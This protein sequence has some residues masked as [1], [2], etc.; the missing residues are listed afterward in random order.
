MGVELTHEKEPACR[1]AQRR[2]DV[3][4][5]PS[6]NGIDF[7]EYA[8]RPADPLPHVL[9]VHFLKDLPDAPHSDPDGAYDLIAHPVWI[10]LQG[11]TRIVNLRVLA[12]TLDAPVLT[13]ALDRAGDFSTYWLSLGW[14]RRPDGSL[15][16]ETP[17]LDA[18]FSRAPV[19]FK[20]DCPSAFDC[21]ED[22]FCPPEPLDEPL[23]D[24][25]AKDYA[26]FRQLLLDLIVQ[27][28][29]DWREL[30]PADL[31]ITLVELL[32]Y[33]GDHLSYFQD[34]V[35]NEAYLETARQRLSV[36]RHARLVDYPVHDGRNAWTHAHMTVAS[37]GTVP[38][39]TRLVTRI[40]DPL[41]GENTPPGVVLDEAALDADVFEADPALIR[42]RVFET[43]HPLAVR[44]EFNSLSIHAWGNLECCLPRGATSLY[45][46][47]QD[48]ADPQQAIRPDLH[49]GD[50]LIFEEIMGPETGLPA[51]ADPAHRQA[52]RLTQV[53][54]ADDGV[55]RDTLLAGALQVRGAADPVLP[56]LRV[57][58]DRGEALSFPLCISARTRADV[59]LNHV[60]LA[61]GNV[62]LADHGRTLVETFPQSSPVPPDERFYLQ[63]N[64]GPLCFQCQPA[65]MRYREDPLQGAVPDDPR[66]DLTCSAGV[67]R[68]AVALIATDSIGDHLWTEVPHLLDSPAHARHFA[69][70]TDNRGRARLRFGDGQYGR[71]ATGTGSFKVTYRVGNGRGGNVGADTLAHALRP[72]IAPAW[73]NITALRNPL[74]AS[75]GQDPETLDQVRLRAPKAFRAEQFRAVTEDDYRDA[76]LLLEGVAGAAARFRWTGSWYTVELAVDPLDPADL[77]T[78]P[79]GRTRLEPAFASRVKAFVTRYRLAGYD[80][81]VR[82]GEY[83]PLEIDIS[84]CVL[85][86][87]F[88][89]DVLQAVT[90][91]LSD[92]INPD[93]TQG[94]FHPDNF[95]FGD[96]LYLS[97]LY[98]A[99]EAV[100]GVDSAEVTRLR[101]FG[102]EDNGELE[103]GVITIGP[104]Q[105]ARLDNDP[106]FQ[107]NGVF[108]L[109]AGG[110]K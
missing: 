26:S 52:V 87:H 66:H 108:R 65:D 47:A 28:N 100:E 70:E 61:R 13:I 82:S 79:G 34:T 83:V 44:P 81:E 6:L 62:A 97:R 15:Q 5:H 59:L 77:I 85:P 69:A 27:R 43:T 1:D 110:G 2:A 35:A 76:A 86:G 99:L 94:L 91:A 68:P 40:A 45:L 17:N 93:G 53:E 104:W 105:I 29:P 4:A 50:Y 64:K 7:V 89:G 48:P 109:S 10:Q 14:S 55:Y 78:L 33:A 30:N 54:E 103:A 19:D 49:A 21:A 57:T 58:W 41:Q 23:L 98:Q 71:E 73:P 37:T 24:Y 72:P 88:R 20:A 102:E 90:W 11:G 84:I 92:E 16:R 32:A 9:V 106:N 101:L 42:A 51:D 39:G 67:A 12:V 95:S 18:R 63:L 31:G 36:R 8:H 60:S 74:A 25:L 38:Q 46:Y 80:L 22:D 107:E 75:G 96:A 3:L 56:L